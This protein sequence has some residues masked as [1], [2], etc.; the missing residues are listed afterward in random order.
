VRRPRHLGFLGSL[1][2]G[3]LLWGEAAT[4][5]E[6]EIPCQ[7]EIR[8]HCAEVQP[9]GGRILE[10]LKRHEASLSPVCVIRVNDLRETFG[11]PMAVCRDDWA[12]L[13]YHARAATDRQGVLQCL[14]GNRDKLSAPCQKALPP[15][16]R[17]Q[18]QRQRAGTP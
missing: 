3:V 9:G 18:P 7:K 5:Q 12:A 15:S 2:F 16:G 17:S 14:Q 6:A 8:T 1:L 13:C 11:G 10:C 4:G